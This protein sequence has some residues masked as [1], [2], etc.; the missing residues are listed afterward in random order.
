M[1]DLPLLF[2]DGSSADARMCAN[3]TIQDDDATEI[4]EKFTVE[5][6]S[7]GCDPVLISPNS[8]KDILILNNDGK[9]L[10]ADKLYVY[11]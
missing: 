2:A 1:D 10:S 7:C 11:L 3:I 8:T 5:L 9:G 4:D 6:S